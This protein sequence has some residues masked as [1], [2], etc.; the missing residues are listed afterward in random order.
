MCLFSRGLVWRVRGVCGLRVCARSAVFVVGV[1]VQPE[2][3]GTCHG[4]KSGKAC[5]VLIVTTNSH[6]SHMD[7]K[8]KER[9]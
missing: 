6:K 7:H 9:V 1:C 4:P 2:R 8:V 5:G 3:R